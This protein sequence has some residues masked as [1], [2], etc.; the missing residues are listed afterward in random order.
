MWIR[1]FAT[2]LSSSAASAA[3][4]IGP[5]PQMNQA[6][7]SLR[8]VD[9]MLDRLVAGLAVEH[10]VEQLD[11]ALLVAEEMIELEPADVAVLQRRQLL[12]GR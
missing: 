10:A 3:S 8:L 7:T 6:S 9:Q 11:V 1:S 2:P 12:R 4:I 5:G